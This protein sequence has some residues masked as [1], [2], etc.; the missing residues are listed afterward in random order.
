MK[1]FKGHFWNPVQPV[2]PIK[3]GLRP[4]FRKGYHWTPGGT[5]WLL[6][7]LKCW[8]LAPPP[9][10]HQNSNFMPPLPQKMNFKT[11]KKNHLPAVNLK[12]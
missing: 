3:L 4:R 8:L 5:L 1:N 10:P 6:S 9:T 7:R 2:R 12:I 11:Q